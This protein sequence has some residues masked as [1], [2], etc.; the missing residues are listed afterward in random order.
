M[1]HIRWTCLLLALLLTAMTFLSACQPSTDDPDKT[2]DDPGETPDDK[3][4]DNPP[5]G[6]KPGEEDSVKVAFIPSE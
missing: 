6:E 1:K 5:D 3:P 2:P 4:D